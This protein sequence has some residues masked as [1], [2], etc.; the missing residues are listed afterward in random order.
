MTPQQIQIN[1]SDEFVVRQGI[2]GVQL[3]IK[4][5]VTSS[6]EIEIERRRAVTDL[7]EQNDF[8]LINPK[9]DASYNLVISVENGLFMFRANAT[10][11]NDQRMIAVPIGALFQS[12]TDYRALS[13]QF[14]AAAR[15]GQIAQMEALDMQRRDLHDKAA[16]ILMTE[17]EQH[18]RM[19]LGT[20]RRLFTLLYVLH[21]RQAS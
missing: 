3:D 6:T 13:D 2:A 15:L 14:Y 21:V 1:T 18:I 10:Q 12:L 11:S 17:T 16:E 20:A 19:D 7:L 4:S 8:S 5:T 9:K